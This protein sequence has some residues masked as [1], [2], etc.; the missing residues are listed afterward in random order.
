MSF[1]RP[2]LLQ[3]KG[4]DE[5]EMD[6]IWYAEAVARI[7][8]NDE[9]FY[10]VFYLIP[11]ISKEGYMV[12]DQNDDI[13]P[14]ES[15]LCYL[16][17]IK[18][19]YD[20]AWGLMGILRT[21]DGLF[22]KIS[23]PE[24]MDENDNEEED[25]ESIGS[26]DSYSTDSGDSDVSDLIDDNVESSHETTCRC[27]ICLDIAITA[28]AFR[29][30]LPKDDKERRVKQFIEDLEFRAAIDNDNNQMNNN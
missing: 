17:V 14:Q 23:E 25:T 29:G 8:K 26:E 28:H 2:T 15:V 7:S 19:D 30:W 5:N 6:C 13:V 20:Y 18:G 10:E 9:I 1:K 22:M 16:P 11:H 12:Y 4:V 21:K 3:I 24:S 27:D